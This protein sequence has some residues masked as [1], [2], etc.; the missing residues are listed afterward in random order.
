M[1]PLL[2]HKELNEAFV[3]SDSI[4]E[5][6]SGYR[7]GTRTN[8][9]GVL[10][11]SNTHLHSLESGAIFIEVQ[12][13]CHAGHR[14]GSP[15]GPLPGILLVSEEGRRSG[16]RRGRRTKGPSP[17]CSASETAVENSLQ[18]A[19]HCKRGRHGASKVAPLLVVLLK[20]LVLAT[21]MSELAQNR[22][23][24]ANAARFLHFRH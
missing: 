4:E 16:E 9:V 20:S 23:A 22:L 24:A 10:Q 19:R 21:L 13:L 15:P 1:C 11:I 8:N 18:R 6:L 12:F 14:E 7:K 3:S 5:A 17:C 2:P